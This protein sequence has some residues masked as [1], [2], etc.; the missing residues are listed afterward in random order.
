MAKTA[1][2]RLLTRQSPLEALLREAARIVPEPWWLEDPTGSVV[3]GESPGAAAQRHP[4]QVAG[5]VVGWVGSTGGAGA[6]IASLLENWLRQENEKRQLGAETLHLYREINLLFSFSE[7]LSTTLGAA[8]IARLTLQEAARVIHFEGGWVFFE[9]KKTGQTEILAAVGRDARAGLEADFLQKMAHSGKSEIRSAP[10]EGGQF[11]C[12]ALAVGGRV[13]GCIVLIG[14]P[15]REF[16]AAD[17]KLLSTLAAPVA[18]ALE[19]AAQHELATAH[20]L[21]EQR[22]QL[23]LELALKN[24][25]FKKMA[26]IAE[27][28]CTDAAFSVAA[29]SEALHLSPSQLQRKIAAITDLTPTQIIR[30]LRLARARYLLQTTDLTVA[31]VSYRSG[32]NDPSY[33]TRLFARE[34]GCTPSEWRSK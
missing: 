1:L 12:A 34:M 32:F 28:R 24:P 8:A 27:A 21:R 10:A 22:E 17:L 13:P 30:D 16:A 20:A 6:F 15:A 19:N 14:P 33:F 7:K 4:V 29:L 9:N 25:F 2:S 3:F 5:E 31:E 26:G 18:A 23:K 11:L